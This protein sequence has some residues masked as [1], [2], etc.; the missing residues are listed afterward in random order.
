MNMKSK[1][2][3]ID[4]LF[5][6][7]EPLKNYYSS[8][9]SFIHLSGAGAPYLK[10]VIDF[11]AFARPLWGLIPYW[12]S[13]GEDDYFA[14]LYRKGIISGTDPKSEGYWGDCTDF[15]QRY[16]EMA[17][18]AFGLMA[19]PEIL[20]NPLSSEEKA[21]LSHWLYQI[22]NHDFS[23]CNWLYFRVLVNTAL[24]VLGEK[25][26]EN[27]ITSD[28]ELIESWYESNGWYKDGV[29]G[30][31]DYYSAFAMMYYPLLLKGLGYG[32]DSSVEKARLFAQ[33]FIY[34]FNNNGEAIPYGRSLTYRFAQAAFWSAAI[35]SE[36]DIDIAVAKGI[37]S[38]NL[39]FWLSNDIFNGDGTLS[40]GYAYPNLSMAENYNAPGSPYW[41]FKLFLFLALDDDHPFWSIEEKESP[42]L[43]EMHK[44]DEAKMIIQNSGWQ[45]TCFTVGNT[46]GKDLGHFV[47]K[48][49]KFAYSTALPMCIAHSQYSLEDAAPDSTIAFRLSDG[50]IAVRRGS[51][52]NELDTNHL[53]TE[54]FV[55]EGIKVSTK[56]IVGKDYHIREHSIFVERD[57]EVF[58][59]GFA[60]KRDRDTKIDECNDSLMISNN[61]IGC[62]VSIVNGN[63]RL[64]TINA[65]PN[66]S[67]MHRNVYIPAIT[68]TLKKGSNVI[69]QTK[70][71]LIH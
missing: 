33:D 64:C 28:L 58:D 2:D 20:W 3:Y 49:F 7:L 44:I 60:V 66:T 40:I 39:D 24:K 46:K 59:C 55:A 52:D 42:E 31:V 45:T 53:S 5:R 61:G 22:N 30:R 16:V 27:A 6:L 19:V 15:D 8:S 71:E 12:K 68:A 37:I 47:D 23:K 54:S 36:A 25:H 18:F 62:K 32:D 65:V 1:N 57:C 13:R 50:F 67:I 51:F 9:G 14:P 29:S 34:W 56:I 11:E 21:R 43:E 17:P 35:F 41:A 10:D 69:L 38:K 48:Y 63:A 70:F 4:I 26:D